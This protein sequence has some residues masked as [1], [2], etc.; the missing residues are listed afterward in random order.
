MI[1][2]DLVDYI[3]A[4]LKKG[5]Y[6]DAVRVQLI[7]QGWQDAD[8]DAAF[9]NV[10]IKD[11]QLRKVEEKKI[12]IKKKKIV[13]AL[14]ATLAIGFYIYNSFFY[15]DPTNKCFIKILPGIELNTPTIKN[16][17]DV[18]K[19]TSVQDYKN[20]CS[21]VD[22]INPNIF[23]CGG[24]EGGC[25]YPQNPTTIQVGTAHNNLSW[26]A[27]VIVH[28]TCHAMQYKEK[29]PFSEQECYK[30]DDRIL[31]QIIAL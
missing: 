3:N 13:F 14:F 9:E 28:E 15:I 10:G 6:K 17:V 21:H 12:P 29:R 7:K 31:R 26:T 19:N 5:V 25:F 22:T 20:L 23:N 16:A 27:G 8:I 2:Q 11:S 1:T 24:F 30:A 18:L 4:S